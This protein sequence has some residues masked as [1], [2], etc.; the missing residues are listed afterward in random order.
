MSIIDGAKRINKEYNYFNEIIEEPKK[1]GKGKLDGI[2]ISVK[3]CICVKNVESRAGSRILS[4]YK[5][6]FDATVVERVKKEGGL[7]I[8]K[9]SQDEFGFWSFN[10]NVVLCI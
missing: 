8:G 1:E 4:G 9:T 5:P 3:D 10:F 2:S 7:V 6:A